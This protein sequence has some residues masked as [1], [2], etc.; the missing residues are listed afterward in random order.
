MSAP[1]AR[2]AGGGNSLLPTGTADRLLP[3][4]G[5]GCRDP[6]LSRNRALRVA[7]IPTWISL[8]LLSWALHLVWHENESSAR[9]WM[10]S[11]RAPREPTKGRGTKPGAGGEEE[12]DGQ[13]CW[14][15]LPETVRSEHC[16]D[17]KGGSRLQQTLKP[18]QPKRKSMEAPEEPL[19]NDL[20]SLSLFT[21]AGAWRTLC[22]H[23]K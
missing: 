23:T 12:G 6:E 15:C 8:L 3:G 21:T 2:R 18:V 14:V 11:G 1:C 4:W 10:G 7:R 9:V 22:L 17:S 16:R 19:G 13:L 20:V 5:T